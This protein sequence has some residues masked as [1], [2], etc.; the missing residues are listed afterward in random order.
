MLHETEHR[1]YDV[2]C[3][4]SRPG[5]RRVPAHALLMLQTVALYVLEVFYRFQQ[6]CFDVSRTV[7]WERPHR[8]SIVMLPIGRPMEEKNWTI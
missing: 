3:F 4:P 7:Q 5:V 8:M 2:N 1:C 6:L